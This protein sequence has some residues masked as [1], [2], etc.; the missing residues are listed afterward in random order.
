MRLAIAV[1]AL[2]LAVLAGG[3]SAAAAQ[4]R[5]IGSAPPVVSNSTLTFP[6]QTVGTSGAPQSVV[7]TNEGPA[8]MS[9]SRDLLSGP[10]AHAFQKASDDCQ[11]ATLAAGATC[12]I[13]YAFVPTATGVAKAALTMFSSTGQSLPTFSLSGRGV[14]PA[15]GSP[16][17]L[18]SLTLS[19]SAFRAAQSGASATSAASKPTGTFIIYSDSQAA[20]TEFIVEKRVHG[21]YKRLGGFTHSDAAG[22]N[23]LRFT[24]RIAGRALAAGSYRLSASAQSAGGASAVRSA[25]FQITR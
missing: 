16:P 24:G 12:A 9:I 17:R 22:T 5:A 23:A 14:A 10:G 1:G 18:S 11:G 2:L 19:A 8:T 13:A 7:L 6:E 4:S 20:I 25:T 15:T 21:R 3:R